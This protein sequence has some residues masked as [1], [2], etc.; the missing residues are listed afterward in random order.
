[1]VEHE[2]RRD[3]AVRIESV[4]QLLRLAF[5]SRALRDSPRPLSG[6]RQGRKRFAQ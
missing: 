2:L 6:V 4:R 1:L 3:G 5:G